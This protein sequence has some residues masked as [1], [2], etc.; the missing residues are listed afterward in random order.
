MI[1]N[2]RNNPNRTDEALARMAADGNALAFDEIYRRHRSFVYNVALRMT[3]NAADAEDLTQESFFLVFRR[4]GSFRGE[5]LFTTW[6]YR[7]VVNRVKMHFRSRSSR[8]GWAMP[9]PSSPAAGA[10]ARTAS[11]PWPPPSTGATISC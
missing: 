2:E 3:R 7:L 4:I 10:A 8:P 5:A 6:L 1:R 9:S 11:R